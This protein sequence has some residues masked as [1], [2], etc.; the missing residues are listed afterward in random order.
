MKEYTQLDLFRNTLPR[1]PYCTDDLG[2]GLSIRPANEAVKHLYIE[3]NDSANKVWLIYDID[4]E[5]ASWDWQDRHVAA[6]NWV[7]MNR[8]NGHAH[9]GYGLEKGVWAQYGVK[10]KAFRYMASVDVAMTK[11]LEAD[12]G[13]S[14]LICKNPLRGD[15]WDV[16]LYQTALY[17]L[18]WL[19]DYLD[20]EPY[21]DARK[22][23]PPIGLGRNC[24]LFDLTR[25]WAYKA[26]RQSWLSREMFEDGVIQHAL[27]YNEANFTQPLA[28]NDVI[29]TSRSIAKWTW[30]H[31]SPAGFNAWGDNRRAKSI[32]V[33]GAS[34]Q[35]K[36]QEVRD[37]RFNSPK[38]TQDEI[39]Q[40]LGISRRSVIRILQ[41][42]TGLPSDITNVTF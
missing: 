35:T 14:K 28:R 32:A 5:T 9:L 22:R 12:P 11:V 8:E 36:A 21:S 39:A 34:S 19:A 25:Q 1:K 27:A 33:R 24:T 10:D 37:L 13:Y 18:P 42:E 40:L 2:F 29:N 26:I 17:D 31:M 4:R 20:L 3:P 41:A 23:L 6:P 30:T 38:L 15:Y 7:A 16:G